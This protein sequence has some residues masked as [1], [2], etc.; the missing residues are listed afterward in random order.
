VSAE[1]SNLGGKVGREL[2]VD[3][4]YAAA[5]LTGL[6][7]LGSLKRALGVLDRIRAWVGVFGMVNGAP[8]SNRQPNVINGSS[9]L[10]IELFGAEAG[11]RARSAV[12]MADLPMDI[13]VEIEAEV[14]VAP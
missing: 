1:L 4:G 6:A 8:C 12:G 3:Q 14:P 13:P 7:I 2:M 5:R 10:I 9:N 11:A